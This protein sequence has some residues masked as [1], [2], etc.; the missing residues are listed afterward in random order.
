MAASTRTIS[1]MSDASSSR[2]GSEVKTPAAS[3]SST[4]S[5]A[6][7]SWATRAAMRSLSPNRISSS[8]TASFSLTIGSTSSSSNRVS[9]ERAWRYCRRLTKSVGANSTWPGTTRPSMASKTSR[10]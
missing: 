4:N 6:P 7:T 10:T 9:V 2:R 3:V 5:S 8:A 1:S